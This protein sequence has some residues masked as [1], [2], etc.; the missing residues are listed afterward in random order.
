MTPDQN[1]EARQGA[2]GILNLNATLLDESGDYAF[3]LFINNVANQHY[4][5]DM[6]DF[7]SSP[8][9]ANAVIV[10]PARD[11]NRYFGAK[12]TASF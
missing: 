9:S 11:S 7:R 6:E 3:T 12:F 1:P 4:V 5:V 10:Q 2:F 8:W